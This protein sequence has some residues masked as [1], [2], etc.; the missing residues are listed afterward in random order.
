MRYTVVYEGDSFGAK[1]LSGEPAP[2]HAVVV[3][4]GDAVTERAAMA[5]VIADPVAVHVN[6][7]AGTIAKPSLANIIHLYGADAL[8]DALGVPTPPRSEGA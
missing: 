5:K 3:S 7:L 2:G 8:R 6:M 4:L 1:I